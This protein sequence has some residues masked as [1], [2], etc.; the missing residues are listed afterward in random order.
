MSSLIARIAP[1]QNAWFAPAAP[2][3]GGPP[4]HLPEEAPPMDIDQPTLQDAPSATERPGTRSLGRA[5]KL[6]RVVA[7]RPQF[8]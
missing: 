5:I 8:G 4:P 1:S 6:M 2:L 7:S 3:S